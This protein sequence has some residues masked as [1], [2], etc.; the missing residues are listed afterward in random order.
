MWVGETI[1]QFLLTHTNTYS[2]SYPPTPPPTHPH[3]HLPRLKTSHSHVPGY[4]SAIRLTNPPHAFCAT[5]PTIHK[6]HWFFWKQFWLTSFSFTRKY[7]HSVSKCEPWELFFFVRYLLV[8]NVCT[9]C[10]LRMIS[11]TF[12]PVVFREWS[13]LVSSFAWT[14]WSWPPSSSDGLITSFLCTLC[15]RLFAIL[16]LT[17]PLYIHCFASCWYIRS[18][19]KRSTD[20][21]LAMGRLTKVTCVSLQWCGAAHK[22]FW[23]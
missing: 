21:L 12:L 5:L 7:L 13:L 2:Y 11:A 4:L 19:Q 9:D 14:R 23:T 16:V 6:P 20:K 15:W 17:S 8:C 3:H 10:I 22:Q 18:R 1:M